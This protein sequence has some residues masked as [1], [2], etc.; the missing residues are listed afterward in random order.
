MATGCIYYKQRV[1]DCY[2]K[3][4]AEYG[5][6]FNGHSVEYERVRPTSLTELCRKIHDLESAINSYNLFVQYAE[7]GDNIPLSIIEGSKQL[8]D[9]NEERINQLITRINEE[10]AIFRSAEQRRVE[11]VE[12]W[13]PRATVVCVAGGL[14]VLAVSSPITGKLA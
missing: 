12:W 9:R 2:N 5:L 11:N 14:L 7:R 4:L 10:R 8:V 13:I 1:Q 6:S 3:A